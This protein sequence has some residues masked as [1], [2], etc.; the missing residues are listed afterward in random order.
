MGVSVSGQG[1]GK[2]CMLVDW[3]G[4]PDTEKSN[5]KMGSCQSFKNDGKRCE[6]WL[7]GK[8]ITTPDRKCLHKK[9]D[10]A[11]YPDSINEGCMVFPP[12][13]DGAYTWQMALDWCAA[14]HRKLVSYAALCPGG[15]G[16][17]PSL[18]AGANKGDL[19]VPVR[20]RNN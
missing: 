1:A 3:A 16:K 6:E 12:I 11:S 8:W 13:S 10:P 4:M 18:F 19:W 14:Y 17:E 9:Y 7:W 5:Y 15:P 2:Q 20:D